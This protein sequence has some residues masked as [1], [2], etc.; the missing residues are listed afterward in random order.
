VTIADAHP[1]VTPRV[2]NHLVRAFGATGEA[3]EKWAEHWATEGLR[4][5]ERLPARRPPSPFALG[6]TPGVADICVAGRGRRAF[7]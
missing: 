4:T 3:I 6:A 2:R 5:Y 1:L 7:P